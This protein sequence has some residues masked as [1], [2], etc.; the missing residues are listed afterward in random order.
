[1]SSEGC[2]RG[3]ELAGLACGRC[4]ECCRAKNAFALDKMTEASIAVFTVK[5]LDTL[6]PALL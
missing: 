5:Q 3:D 2:C 1:M 6:A 4:H